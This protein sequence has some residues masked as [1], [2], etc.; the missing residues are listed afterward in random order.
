MKIKSEDCNKYILFG[1]LLLLALIRLPI[2]MQEL[3]PFQF[4]DESMF[5]GEVQRLYFANEWVTHEFRSGGFNIYPVLILTKILGYIYDLSSVD[6]LLI[7]RYFY[8]VFLALLSGYGFYKVGSIVGG[9]I[10]GVIC[11]ALYIISPYV[12]SISRYW[13]PDH[14]IAAAVV[15]TNYYAI[16][17]YKEYLDER[18]TLLSCGAL[19]GVCLS[20]K[21]TA[22][23]LLFPIGFYVVG[24]IFK[25]REFKSSCKIL[26]RE[27]AYFAVAAAFVW[28][29]FNFSIFYDFH[30]FLRGFIFNVNN[31][32][33]RSYDRLDGIIFYLVT[34]FVLPLGCL[35]VILYAVGLK[36]F[37]A[38]N[39]F[40]PLV[41]CISVLIYVTVM[42]TVNIVVNRNSAII[43]PFV[44]PVIAAGLKSMLSDC[45]D[46]NLGIRYLSRII[47]IVAI[48]INTALVSFC[49][50]E[51]LN[52]DS[53]ILARDW[54]LNNIPNNSIVGVNEFCSGE[55]PA[56]SNAYRII[57]DPQFDKKLNYYV[58]NSYWSSK[59]DFY[60]RNKGLIQQWDQKYLHF[61]NFNDRS[62][63]KYD[64]NSRGGS[65]SLVV[66]DYE[67]I[68]SFNSNGPDI[69]IYKR[70]D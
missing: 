60:S 4:C 31:Y 21:Y 45:W 38:D 43:I 46:N 66:N 14:Y 52:V 42:G 47:G 22:I 19:F 3:P 2:M 53:R 50:I 39:Y 26:G 49:F 62:V 57:Y 44:F 65:S 37:P 70:K 12:Y 20:I 8:L 6:I 13:Y 51:D 58:I 59:L 29:V 18:K 68:R 28:L 11:I 40:V 64:T 54:I 5:F 23:L 30:G 63:Y 15:W 36:K 55:S 24:K 48:L 35:G 61:Y 9:N 34:I 1:L 32:G 56:P 67:L 41:S 27:L 69:F 25:F 10:L 16:K 33:P 17:Y 7:G